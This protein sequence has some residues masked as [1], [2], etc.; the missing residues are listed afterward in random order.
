MVGIEMKMAWRNVWRNPRRSVLTACAI[1]FACVL[2]IFMLSFQFGSYETMINASVKIHTGHL[3]VQ[4]AGYREKRRM[5]MVVPKPDEVVSAISSIDTV[6]AITQ[7]ANAFSMVSSKDRTYG[8]LVLGV[9]PLTE[10]RVSNLKR[11]ITDGRY[12]GEAGISK[13]LVPAL[14]GRSLSINLKASIGDEL[15]I[16]GQGRDGSVAATV[17]RIIGV[18]ASGLDD[19]DRRSVVIPL[20]H[21]QDIY[22][23]DGSVHE[24]VVIGDR[25]GCVPE[26]KT[27]VQRRLSERFSN[28]GLVVLDWQA[29]VP[30]L[31]QAISMDLVSGIIMYLI[32]VI[33]VAFSILNTFLM[34]I[35]ER[36]HEF[37]VL[38]AIG[39]RP[40]RLT[41]VLVAESAVLTLIG[42]AA[43]ILSGVALT[44]YFQIH[45]IDVSNASELLSRYGISGKIHPRLSMTTLLAGPA[46]VFLITFLSALYPAVKIRK[47]SPLKALSHV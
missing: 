37:G 12:F 36:T 41:R 45:G 19:F 11:T 21:F 23:M 38:M 8:A 32:L 6:K 47:M 18:F 42:I 5:R 39:V 25:L 4:A 7:R 33:V 16:M 24:I 30:G 28:A 35:F 43:G 29:L 13:D 44:L 10:A 31:K 40:A 2:L 14:I 3:Q 20:S 26:I 46:V 9:D 22:A 17:V 1:C 15:T 34:A 27:A